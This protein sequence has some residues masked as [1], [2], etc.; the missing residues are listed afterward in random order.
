MDIILDKGKGMVIGK[1]RTI[2]LIEADLQYVMRIYLNNKE[3]EVIEK[4][5][6]ISKSNYGSRKNYSIKIVLLEKRLVMDN[7]L[8]TC[9]PT[10]YH[11]TDLKLYY[12]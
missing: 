10:I 11:L 2:M 3:R 9:N 6:K 1:L 8:L 12:D 5:S 4:D 7:I